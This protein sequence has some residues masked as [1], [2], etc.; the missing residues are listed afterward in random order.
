M[1]QGTSILLNV[2]IVEDGFDLFIRKTGLFI[3]IYHY[4]IMYS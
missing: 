2:N 4:Q 3:F 1:I